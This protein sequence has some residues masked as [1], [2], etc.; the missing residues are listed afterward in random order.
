MQTYILI[1]WGAG[2]NAENLLSLEAGGG[3]KVVSSLRKGDFHFDH[4]V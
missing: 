1:F 3:R 4:V 2:K